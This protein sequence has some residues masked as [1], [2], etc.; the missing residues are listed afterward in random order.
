MN[1]VERA[2]LLGV[3]YGYA[4]RVKGTPYPIA[5]ARAV[6][7]IMKRTRERLNG[8]LVDLNEK[9]CANRERASNL[10]EVAVARARSKP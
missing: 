2:F 4:Q 6:V 9:R 5:L 7:I 8:L 1:A 10:D 3:E